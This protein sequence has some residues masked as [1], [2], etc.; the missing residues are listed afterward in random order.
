MKCFKGFIYYRALKAQ[1]GGY[2]L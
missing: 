2:Y 1:M